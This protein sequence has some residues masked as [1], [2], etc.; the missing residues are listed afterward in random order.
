VVAVNNRVGEE[1][2]WCIAIET[3]NLLAEMDSGS[4]R[5][6]GVCEYED[7]KNGSSSVVLNVR[8]VDQADAGG[9]LILL[10]ITKA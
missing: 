9:K 8:P 1:N 7:A 2:D 6:V 5:Q 3:S 4:V 10:V